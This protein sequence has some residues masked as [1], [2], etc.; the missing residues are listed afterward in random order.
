MAFFEDDV[1]ISTVEAVISEKAKDIGWEQGT[2]SEARVGDDLQR[3]STRL[4][5]G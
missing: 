5:A 1:D 2:T 4:N 3:A